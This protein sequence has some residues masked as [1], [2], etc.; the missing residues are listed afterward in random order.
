MGLEEKWRAAN[1]AA[2]AGRWRAR[3]ASWWS[4]P[5]LH[6][7]NLWPAHRLHIRVWLTTRPNLV[8]I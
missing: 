1:F 8:G 7:V 6:R 5:G 2:T 3:R 4:P